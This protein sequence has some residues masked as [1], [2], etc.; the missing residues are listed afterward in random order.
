MIRFD[1]ARADIELQKEQWNKMQAAIIELASG[2]IATWPGAL[3]LIL[4]TGLIGAI[5]DNVRKRGLIAGL[6]RNK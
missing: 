3:Q 1:A 4:G 6:K 2:S 5:G